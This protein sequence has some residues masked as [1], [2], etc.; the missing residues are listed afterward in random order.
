MKTKSLLLSLLVLLAIVVGV[1]AE[2]YDGEGN[3][4][5]LWLKEYH[6]STYP[7]PG[8]M[9][10]MDNTTDGV[11]IR[12]QSDLGIGIEA[13]SNDTGL[14]L[15]TEGNSVFEGD[16]DVLGTVVMDSLN[17]PTG[18][19]EGHVLTS[20]AFGTATWQPILAVPTGTILIWTTDVPPEGYLLCDGSE[21]SRSTYAD[22]FSLIGTAYGIGNGVD[23][24]NIPDLRGRFPLGQ[25]DMGGTPADRIT[26]TEADTLGGEGGAESHVHTVHPPSTNTS[27]AILGN[28]GA[29][30]HNQPSAPHY[31]NVSIPPFSSD[32][33][34]HQSPFLTL[35]FIVKY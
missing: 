4:D 18:A 24:F 32:S 14:A 21:V 11:A 6:N 22:L 16:V 34:N 10:W 27:G 13:V 5:G 12:G 2:W 9:I 35:N 19:T 15:R 30:M 7:S 25:D 1:S 23:T 8:G 29:Y 33:E 17:I 20:D 31:H 26:N 3:L 28:G